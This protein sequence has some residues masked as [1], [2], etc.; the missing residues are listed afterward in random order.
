[1]ILLKI[2]P[3]YLT[4]FITCIFLLISL[5][6]AMISWPI[7]SLT[8]IICCQPRRSDQHHEIPYKKNSCLKI[9]PRT[10][11]INDFKT[12]LVSLTFGYYNDERAFD[13]HWEIKERRKVSAKTLI[14]LH[15]NDHLKGRNIHLEHLF[16]V[17]VLHLVVTFHLTHL[18]A[19]ITTADIGMFHRG[20]IQA[21]HLLLLPL[22][23]HDACHYCRISAS[24]GDAIL[25]E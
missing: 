8:S 21:V 1:M 14:I 18:G 13:L 11:D 7:T 2:K 5:Q 12:F 16:T 25:S 23:L 3:L 20:S 9:K 22:L 10:E 19:E 17:Q 6:S 4:A 24:C 15:R